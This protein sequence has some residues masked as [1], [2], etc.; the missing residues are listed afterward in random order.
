ME[1]LAEAEQLDARRPATATSR[2]TAAFSES[3]DSTENGIAS[4]AIQLVSDVA[5][6]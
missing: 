6:G 3:S 5:I 4:S 1:R 2:S